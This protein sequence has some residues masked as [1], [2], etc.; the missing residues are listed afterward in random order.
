MESIEYF[1]EEMR[2]KYI[3]GL[4]KRL[5]KSC[6]DFNSKA[7]NF[8]FEYEIKDNHVFCLLTCDTNSKYMPTMYRM[9]T[10]DAFNYQDIY[11]D[12]NV[13]GGYTLNDV[14]IR[15]KN[16]VNHVSKRINEILC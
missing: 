7:S 8:I 14:K 6:I 2:E 5:I 4:K 15:T 1:T 3:N 16:Y 11:F 9:L 12:G 10:V 13:C